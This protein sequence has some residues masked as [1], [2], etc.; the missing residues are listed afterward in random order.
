M[1]CRDCKFLEVPPDK[2][3]RRVPRA[4]KVYDCTAPVPPLP[5]SCSG[6]RTTINRVKMGPNDGLH[7]APCPTYETRK[8]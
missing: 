7:P 2:S 3:G 6:S 4:D 5:L 1:P 8:A